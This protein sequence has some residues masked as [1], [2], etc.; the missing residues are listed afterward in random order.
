VD[1]TSP[2]LL[3]RLRQQPGDEAAW[4]R[5]DSLYRPLLKAWLRQ[6]AL[7]EQDV[8]DLVQQVLE[9]LVRELPQFRY[10]PAK[11]RFRAWLRGV[12]VNRVKDFWRMQRFRPRA[13]ATSFATVLEHLEDPES[14][15][16]RLWDRDHDRCVLERL[17]D[18]VRRDFK[19]STWEAFHLVVMEG[20]PIVQ[21]AERV[22]LTPN[23]VRVAKY[24][25]LNRLRQEASGLLDSI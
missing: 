7:Q 25:V 19:P 23:A 2:S 3:D 4:R 21:V 20:L 13:D 8:D 1:S 10:D 24:H 12:L 15:L 5:F 6:Y 11:G 9:V 22:A 17:L 16:S 14:D 18:L